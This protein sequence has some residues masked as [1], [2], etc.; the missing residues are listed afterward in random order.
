MANLNKLL[1][2]IRHDDPF[3]RLAAVDEL[4]FTREPPSLQ[5][6]V[7]PALANVLA[8]DSAEKVRQAAAWAL[9]EIGGASVVAL[10]AI[11]GALK[12]SCVGIR[13]YAALAI[14]HMGTEAKSAL[15]AL[16]SSLDDADVDVRRWIAEAILQ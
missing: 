11:C 6:V 4:A 8:Q 5:S 16:V 15:P 9:M 12:E 2:N 1:R 7:V 10:P 3:V 13:Y 14:Y